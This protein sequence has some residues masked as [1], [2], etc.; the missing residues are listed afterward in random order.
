MNTTRRG[1][2]AGLAAVAIA[3]RA[4]AQGTA[5]DDFSRW[6]QAEIDQ[7]AR[8]VR[9]SSPKW[10]L[11]GGAVVLPQGIHTVT[12]P[13]RLRSGV[14]ILGTHQSTTVLVSEL[15]GDDAVFE[16]DPD[17][18]LYAVKVA[19][20]HA[21]SSRPF[22]GNF[23]RIFNANRNCILE[24]LFIEQFRGAIWSRD[25]F[26]TVMRDIGVYRCRDG[27]VGENFTNG[28]LYNTKVENCARDGLQLGPSGKNTST[29]THVYDFVAQGNG[30]CGISVYGLDQ[31]SFGTIFLEGNN[32]PAMRE[33]GDDGEYAQIRL[34][35]SRTEAFKRNGNI[36]FR[37]TFV[38]PG[39][40]KIRGGAAIDLRS[41]ENVVFD[42]G[43][44]RTFDGGFDHAFA[45]SDQVAR[46]SLRDITFQ[47]FKDDEL[48]L[49]GGGAKV[50]GSGLLLAGSKDK[51]P[52]E[53]V[54]Q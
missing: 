18:E 53:A 1:I 52:T 11:T 35:A 43:F 16:S 23:I 19:N 48:L 42:G 41:A 33:K 39:H 51:P 22:Q 46:C 49:S 45:V 32:R 37:D 14:P 12:R 28:R 44:M 3:P 27:I 5:P 4:F 25:C 54:L 29:G 20:L 8:T 31:I 38:T 50:D 36:T 10:P 9:A 13:I 6:L 26:T 7:K 40:T 34:D 21:V 2:L 17:D 15:V 24:Q 47:G 30:R